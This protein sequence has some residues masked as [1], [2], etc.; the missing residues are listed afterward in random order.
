MIHSDVT[1][2]NHTT[3]YNPELVNI[4]GCT[5]GNNCNIGTFVEIKPTVNIGNYVKI[6]AF[7]FIPEGIIIEDGVF[8]G[9]H[10]T[11]TND[12]YPN[13]TNPDGTLKTH[14]D[15]NIL[16]TVVKKNASIG[17][18]SI[19][20]PGITIGE[21]AVIGAGS[22]VTKDVPA[23]TTVIGNPARIIQKK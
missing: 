9:P 4:Y 3:I 22:V 13:S 16:K 5:I 10:V 8:I 21:S 6:Q 17:A 12:K 2:G 23:F 15:W 18:G 7:V 19:I 20:L 1:I 14:K 11:F